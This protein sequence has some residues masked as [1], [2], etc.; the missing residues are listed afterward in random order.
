MY[1]LTV[2]EAHTFFVGAGVVVGDGIVAFSSGGGGSSNLRPWI[3]R[4]GEDRRLIKEA[5]KLKGSSLEDEANELIRRFL[6]GNP[7]PGR[8][9][10]RLRGF[11]DV[12]ELRGYEGARVY[13][14]EYNGIIEILGKSTKHN[15]N[16]VIGILQELYG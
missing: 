12:Y 2:A 9:T 3:S 7:N 14:R 8:W 11:T 1:N 5:N 10:R 16:R 15:Q 4:I 6:Q 13:F